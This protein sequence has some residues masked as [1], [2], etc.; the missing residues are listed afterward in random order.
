MHVLVVTA[1]SLTAKMAGPAIRAMHMARTLAAEHE[2]RLVSVN[3]SELDLPGL[4][5]THATGES[6]VEHEAWC[7][8]LIV[9]GHVLHDEPVLAATDKP[10]VADVYDPVHLEQLEQARDLGDRER[11]RAVVVATAVLNE[12]LLRADFLICASEKQRDF[13]LGQLSA[14]GRINTVAYDA[15]ET[16]RALIDV[17]PFGLEDSIPS[18]TRRAVKGV[19]AGIEPNDQVVLWGGGIYNWFDPLSLIRAMD[20]LRHRRPRAKLLFLGLAH[21]NAL[22]PR[23]RM[24][25]QAQ[26]LADSLGLTG[27]S[28]FFNYGWVD[29]ADRHHYL[30]EADVGVS[31]HLDHVETAYSFRTRMLDYL[32]AGLPIVCTTGD[33]LSELVERRSLGL[34]VP[35]GDPLAIADALDRLLGD[36]ALR[37][38]VRQRVVATAQDF[39]WSTVLRPVVQFCRA[40]LRAPDLLD[41]EVSAR[42]AQPLSV[43]SPAWGG[44]RGD[45]RLVRTY[46]QQGGP[47]LVASK[48]VGRARRL[49]TGRSPN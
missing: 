49:V 44:V 16:L 48:A 32:W 18:A 5:V 30:L 13:W 8:V 33:S 43:P 47:R 14:L 23:M 15:D 31:T 9:Q 42:L 34:T 6:L 3:V 29:Y 24:A 39:R 19:I 46:V 1:D 22:V 20:L 2:V 7:D 40:P 27:R 26:E 36:D 21:P 12:Q 25:T 4:T 38:E 10:V 17:A 37:T 41:P 11:R 35:P 45:L 28:V